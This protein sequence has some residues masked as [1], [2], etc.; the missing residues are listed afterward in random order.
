MVFTVGSRSHVYQFA[1]E[2]DGLYWVAVGEGPVVV[3]AHSLQDMRLP[4]FETVFYFAVA[5]ATEGNK[6]ALVDSCGGF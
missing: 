1:R 3:F 5:A 2:G 4:G 6:E